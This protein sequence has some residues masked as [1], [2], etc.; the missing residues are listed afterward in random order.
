[1]ILLDVPFNEKEQAKSL[2]ARWNPMEKKWYIPDDLES[3]ADQF[4]K[5]LPVQQ[6]TQSSLDMDATPANEQNKGI[7]LSQLMY[8]VQ[9][10]LRQSF[11]GAVWVKAEVANLNER[12]GHYYFELSE[13][14]DAGGQPIATCR[15]MIWQ[16]QVDRILTRFEQETGSALQAGQNI[17]L[18]AEV[19]FHEK[20]GFSLVIQD[21]DPSFTLGE[22]EANLHKIRQQLVAEGLYDQNKQRP[23]PQDYFRLAVIAPPNA[24]GL[25]DFRADADVLQQ[26]GL[27]EFKYFYSAFQ[28]EQV[29]AEMLAAFEA[30]LALHH[31]QPFDA[32]IIIRGGGAKLDLNPLN[33]YALAKQIATSPIAVLTGI[34]HERDNTLLDEVA[35]MRFDT[36]SKVIAA[37]RQTIFQGAQKAQQHWFVIEKASR[38]YVHEQKQT[39]AQL[40]KTVQQLSL[41][42]TEKLKTQLAPLHY[43]I[44]RQ[45]LSRL[46]SR[47][48]A[49]IQTQQGIKHQAEALLSTQKHWLNQYHQIIE[50]LPF[51]ALKEAKSNNKQWIRFILSSGPKV[52]LNRGFTMVKDTQGQPIKSVKVA[53]RKSQI[54]IVF[55]DGTLNA[56]P[57]DDET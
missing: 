44:Q 56:I 20:F 48:H 35:A 37:I 38:L 3:Q 15:A 13:T 8:Q 7:T 12:R 9:G 5:W 46:Q 29:E 10:A 6:V 57:M 36:P 55:H 41:G 4:Q 52:Q 11:P 39:L 22:L 47:K 33:H 53:Q 45:S 32:L 30:F 49:M 51:K 23:I 42:M 24:A 28:G 27:C 43:Q 17:L 2:G 34:G 50:T 25:G 18:L 19:N 1:M 40:E 54:Q 14:S 26:T 31:S 16:R 21:I